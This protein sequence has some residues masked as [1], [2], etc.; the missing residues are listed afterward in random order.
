[1][2]QEGS[3]II[4]AWVDGKRYLPMLI[5]RRSPSSRPIM[6]ER[7]WARCANIVLNDALQAGGEATT[8]EQLEYRLLHCQC[9]SS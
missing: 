3:G 7:C 5:R 4:D 2:M 9:N 1:M 6:D 8:S